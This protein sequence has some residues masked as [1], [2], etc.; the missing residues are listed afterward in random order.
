MALRAAE[1]VSLLAGPR[2][3]AVVGASTNPQSLSGRPLRYLLDH[4]FAGRIV[5]VHH[6]ASEVCGVPAVASL[7]DLEPG[8][9]D[10]VLVVLPAP[11]VLDALAAAE[12]IGARAAVVIGS[13]F[14]DRESEPRRR[15]DAFIA[16]RPRLRII[17]PNCVGTLGVAA[18]AYLTFSSVLAHEV[19]RHGTLGLVTQSG[20]LGNSLLQTLIRRHVGVSQWISTGDEVDAG[21]IEIA[22][23]M[24]QQEHVTA[25][26]LFLEGVTD[27]QWLPELEAVLRG[28]H[29]RLFV[30]KGART[31]QGRQAAVGHTGRVV[32]S[33][34]AS[35]AILAELGARELPSVAALAD[36][37]VVAGTCPQLL[38]I[39][40]ARTCIVSVSGAAGVIGADRVAGENRLAMAEIG[41]SAATVLRGRLDPRL[42]PSN[43][44]DVPFVGETAPFADAVSAYS[45]CEDVDVVVA[46]E[47]GLAHDRAEMAA[48]LIA[49]RG[50]SPVL[51]TS[52]SEDDQV[53]SEVA[54]QL[55]GAGIPCL[56]TVERAVA[57][58]AACAETARPGGREPEHHAAVEGLEWA[59]ERLPENFPWA[60]WR[61]VSDASSLSVAV[62]ELGLPL[63]VKAAG[64][65]IA[66]RT[67]LGAVRIARGTDEVAA[68]F[69]S[70]AMVC[71][72]E[73]DAVVVQKFAPSGFEVMLSAMRDREFGPVVFL[74]PG[75]TYTERMSGSTVLWSGWSRER[76]DAVLSDSVLGELLDGYRGGRR[77]DLRALGDLVDVALETVAAQM[78][79][80]ELNPVITGESGVHVVDAIAR[81]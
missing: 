57:A 8:S 27:P 23:G 25:V 7:D 28:G 41:A 75:G 22:T 51:L 46:V 31:A 50:P 11:G 48:K 49:G 4:G 1:L 71:D 24:L 74:R 70:V 36:A 60:H 73:R 72:R 69:A 12:R 20:A 42:T 13:G 33:A 81:P 14:E 61:V 76:R 32:G 80:L 44:V 16:R 43:P 6:S 65:T 52:L 38:D 40:Q 3:V 9:I 55:A 2:S 79:F 68:A 77:Y 47:S 64:R 63:V 56:P 10:V 58:V 67:E 45:S 29:K 26:G 53:P 5:P 39:R 15:L 19:P 54:A 37:L 21:A 17:G 18:G 78:S 35:S 34:T 59:A 66:H 62:A 30:L